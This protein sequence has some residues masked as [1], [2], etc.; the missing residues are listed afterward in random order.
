ME[1]LRW[2][3]HWVSASVPSGPTPFWPP[4]PPRIRPGPWGKHTGQWVAY[5][6]CCWALYNGSRGLCL[7]N[8]VASGGS[9]MPALFKK[10]HGQ[11][12]ILCQGRWRTWAGGHGERGFSLPRI[13]R[14]PG[15]PDLG[16]REHFPL[17]CA[18][19]AK[20]NGSTVPPRGRRRRP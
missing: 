12:H 2:A 7:C 17:A 10:Q 3:S 14:T 16:A 6:C 8:G 18:L 20:Q 9:V 5:C 4:C 11:G 13:A 1:V 15:A 19:Q